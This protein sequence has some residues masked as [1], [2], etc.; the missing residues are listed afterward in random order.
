MSHLALASS[1]AAPAP[2]VDAPAKYTKAEAATI[3]AYQAALAAG[4]Y[5]KIFNSGSPYARLISGDD[6]ELLPLSFLSSDFADFCKETGRSLPAKPPTDLY[7]SY[8]LQTVTGTIFT[9]NGPDLIRT[10][11]SR[12]RRVNVYKPFERKH[13]AIDLSPL[14]P[15]FLRRMF[16]VPAELHTFCQY[17][18]HAIRFPDERPSWHL[19][20][21]SESGVGKGFIF[22][23]IISPL[24]T[25]QTKLVKSFA[26]VTGKFGATVLEGS[27]FVMLDDCK[28]GSDSTQTQMKSMLSEEWIYVEP[29]GKDGAMVKIYTRIMLASNEDVPV[30]VDD[31]TR[32][33][34]IPQKLGFC[35]GLK[36]KVGQQERQVRIKALAKWMKEPGAMEA[37]YEFFA[38]YPLEATGDYPEFDPK[39]VPITASF[40]RMVEKSETVEQGFMRDTLAQMT[41]N[42]LKVGELIAE[43]KAEGLRPPGNGALSELFGF[44]GYRRET[45][46]VRGTPSRFWFP[47]SMSIAEATAIRE[48]LLPS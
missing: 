14:F 46:T 12:H 9:P 5:F 13:P 10:G 33:W 18:G 36:G 38:A 7:L 41:T 39:N 29:K 42:V 27:M 2:A 19:M 48:A 25:M 44:C 26:A 8:S 43:F 45:L 28:A 6:P 24:F 22:G 3:E 40:E 16:P 30:P 17:I 35:N 11:R 47:V 1:N 23:D 20:L 4:R 37:I 15:D 31:Q 32:R 21:P 34:W